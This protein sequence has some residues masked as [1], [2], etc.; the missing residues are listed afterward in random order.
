M[1]LSMHLHLH[2]HSEAHELR[3]GVLY[4]VN[5]ND[6]K[7]PSS[8]SKCSFQIN[9]SLLQTTVVYCWWLNEHYVGSDDPSKV[10]IGE[11]HV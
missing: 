4:R 7:I 6:N 1:K 10:E 9:M 11:V 8:S 3:K 5:K 2:V